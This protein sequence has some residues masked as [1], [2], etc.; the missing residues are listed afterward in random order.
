MKSNQLYIQRA[1]GFLFLVLILLSL[2]GARRSAVARAVDRGERIPILLFGL[3]AAD[4]S[5]H[6]DTLMIAVLDSLANSL[7]LLSIPRDT[8]VHLEGYLFRRVNEVYGFHF[9][10]TRDRAAASRKVL[11]A[12]QFLLSKSEKA[13]VIPHY[14]QV[15]FSGFARIMDILGGV[16]VTVKQPM[17]YDDNA[18][19]YHFHKEPGRYYLRGQEALF[20]VR[21]RGATGDKGR[22]FRQQEFLKSVIKKFAN[23]LVVLRIP[24]IT[25]AV[26]ASIHTDLSLWDI[27]YL[28]SAA[29]RLRSRS[30]EFYILPGNPRGAYWK[31]KAD[32]AHRLAVMAIL[33]EKVDVSD[34]QTIAPLAKQITIKVWNA[35][36]QRG[37]AHEVTK[38]LRQC[39]YDVV[40]WENFSTKQLPTRVID[41]VWQIFKAQAVADDL[42]IDNFH[43]EVSKKSMVDVEVVLGKNFSRAGLLEGK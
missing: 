14:L 24:E 2:D 9:R 32:E 39:G 3:D 40:E 34:I 31:L 7:S 10:K 25:A 16:W 38:Y 13:I 29:R 18:G 27:V 33:G 42:G 41:R 26:T 30:L 8:R 36:G 28:A 19:N 43:S 23:P 20:Y 4:K 37:L 22:I 21:F 1:V 17:H 35:S 15:D 6:T 11:E 12:V 5:R